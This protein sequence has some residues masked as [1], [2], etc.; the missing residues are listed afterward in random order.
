MVSHIIDLQ[1][2]V[3]KELSRFKKKEKKNEV[4]FA[5]PSRILRGATSTTNGH[6][7]LNSLQGPLERLPY[8]GVGLCFP[9]RGP[10]KGTAT[11]TFLS[12][13]QIVRQYSTNAE[14]PLSC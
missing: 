11:A 5:T 3:K 4:T 7:I 9:E 12:H 1:D 2:T 14:K 10:K 8:A 6:R 13:S